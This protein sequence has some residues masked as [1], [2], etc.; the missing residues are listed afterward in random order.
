[1]PNIKVK[2]GNNYQTRTLDG[3]QYMVFPGVIINEGV[4]NGMFYSA[5]ELQKLPEQWNGKPIVID[6]PEQFNANTPDVVERSQVGTLFNS[7]FENGKIKSEFWIDKNKLSAK[8][9]KLYQKLLNGGMFEVSTGLYCEQSDVQGVFNGTSYKQIAQNL[10]AEHLAILPDLEGACSIKDGC[11]FPRWNKKSGIKNE[12]SFREISDQLRELLSAKYGE[13]L[14]MPGEG[15]DRYFGLEAVY[16]N[17]VVYFLEEKGKLNFYKLGYSMNKDIV[18]L[19]EEEPVKVIPELSY[20]EARNMSE[21]CCPE[22]VKALIK[23]KQTSFVKTD[24]EWLSQL[25]ESQIEKIENSIAE[26]EFQRTAPPVP[27]KIDNREKLFESEFVSAELKAE[28]K[29]GLEMLQEKKKGLVQSILSAKNN[30]FSEEELNSKEISELEKLEKL[31]V[32]EEEESAPVQN[33]FAGAEGNREREATVNQKQRKEEEDDDI[34]R[35]TI[36]TIN[37]GRSEKKEVN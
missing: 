24:E 34:P 19:N 25:N 9:P 6:H 30:E 8:F 15:V 7:V 16:K 11:G 2:L 17:S 21:N 27:K 10:V 4:L 29:A 33:K 35:L 18:S 23:N 31:T 32:K 3:K 14:N 13:W 12:K 1:M 5:E 20:K 26:E 37:W 22:R 36:S 28:I